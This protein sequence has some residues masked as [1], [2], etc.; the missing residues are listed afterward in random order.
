MKKSIILI[1][2]AVLLAASPAYGWGRLGHATVAKIAEDYMTPKAKKYINEYLHGSRL[3]ATPLIRMI[4]ARSTSSTSVSML[5]TA[6][7]RPFGDTRSRH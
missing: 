5:Q 1:L 6:L 3:S 7:V 2:G 4:I